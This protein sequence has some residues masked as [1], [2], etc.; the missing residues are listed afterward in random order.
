ME[1]KLLKPFFHGL[2]Q[3]CI[4]WH[5]L[6]WDSRRLLYF[7]VEFEAVNIW[8]IYASLAVS[9]HPI[10]FWSVSIRFFTLYCFEL[11]TN[12]FTVAF[13]TFSVVMCQSFFPGRY[14]QPDMT[15][16]NLQLSHRFSLSANS[17]FCLLVT[18]YQYIY[19]RILYNSTYTVLNH[20]I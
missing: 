8:W 16:Y 7:L 6:L 12:S 2:R 10:I 13:L 17:H 19:V 4:K 5:G 11:L 14:F 20:A 15:L 3:C 1:N 9:F 18:N